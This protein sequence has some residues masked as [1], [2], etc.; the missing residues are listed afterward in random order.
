M[1]TSFHLFLLAAIVPLSANGL[2]L[3][4]SAIAKSGGLS[5]PEDR[6]LAF[7]RDGRCQR[8]L[9][10]CQAQNQEGGLATE[11]WLNDLD[12]LA[13]ESQNEIIGMIRDFVV[14]VGDFDSAAVVET[15]TQ[16]SSGVYAKEARALVQQ[17]RGIDMPQD[18][19]P[20]ELQAATESMS[21]IARD[22]SNALFFDLY[23]RILEFC[24][25]VS[26]NYTP[27]FFST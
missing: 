8:R 11:A 1:K 2:D 22:D 3:P 27:K 12:A 7:L 9:Q 21:A 6:S 17:V 15:Y 4:T 25:D 16:D 26:L 14:Q 20:E 19:S 13:E 23:G 18:A 24:L 5:D 10:R